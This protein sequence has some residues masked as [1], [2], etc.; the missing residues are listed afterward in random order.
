MVIKFKATGN[1]ETNLVALIQGK[2]AT[3]L[4]RVSDALLD[5]I[6]GEVPIIVAPRLALPPP[7]PVGT[8]V[9]FGI[10]NQVSR[11]FPPSP[12]LTKLI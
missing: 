7:G 3:F 10:A 5:I 1:C 12:P 9:D 4:G 8:F 2:R 6:T 11:P